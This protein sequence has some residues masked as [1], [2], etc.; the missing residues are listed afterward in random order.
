MVNVSDIYKSYGKN[1]ILSGA[2]LTAKPGELVALVGKNGCGKST[3]LQI[4]AGTMKADSG[5][6]SYFE[7]SD[8]KIFEKFTGFVPQN[9]PL[10]EDLSVYDNLRFWAAGKEI[11]TE[12]LKLFELEDLL[13]VKVSTLSGGMK[14]R[15]SIACSLERKPPV[16]L[17]DE[18]SSALDFYYQESIHSWMLDFKKRN[19][20]IIFSTHN[21]TEILISDVVYIFEDGI[22]KRI[23]KENINMNDIR[24]SFLIS[25]K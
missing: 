2:S 16:M 24:N 8:R 10:L 13:K 15:L 14:R 19:G 7:R 18:P 22:L 17:M 20:I 11:D 23:E 5:M 4:M 3:L 12:Y 9:D 6:I 1:R 25:D 21:E